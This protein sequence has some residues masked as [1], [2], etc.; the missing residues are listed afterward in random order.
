[1]N[2]SDCL[3]RPG[4]HTAFTSGVLTSFLGVNKGNL[5]PV[6]QFEII[7]LF[8]ASWGAI[9]PLLICYGLVMKQP[10]KVIHQLDNFRKQSWLQDNASLLF[11]PFPPKQLPVLLGILISAELQLNPCDITDPL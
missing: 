10:D 1:M 3:S 8:G 4:S 11:D 5:P 7:P 6:R 9:C 2:N